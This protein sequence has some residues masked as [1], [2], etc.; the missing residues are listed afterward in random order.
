MIDKSADTIRITP[1]DGSW[2]ATHGSQ[3]F[4]GPEE[5]RVGEQVVL[6]HVDFYID[7]VA[8]DAAVVDRV[9]AFR[10]GGSAIVI[11]EGFFPYG[12]QPRFTQTC[13]YAANH[14]RVT[15]DLQWPRGGVVGRHLG[16]GGARLP[17]AW[18]RYRCV[19]PALHLAHET[20]SRQHALAEP[21][22]PGTMAGH[23]HRP[24]L[25]LVFEGQDGT[26]CE[27]GTGNDIWRWE[28]GLGYG[29]ESGSFKIMHEP[30]GLRLIREP[31]MCCEPF[32]PKPRTY[33]FTWYAAW[34]GKR[35][36]AADPVPG[37]TV[38]MPLDIDVHHGIRNVDPSRPLLLDFAQIPWPKR[39]QRAG[40]P[41][42]FARD[43]RRGEPCWQSAGVQKLARRVIR[44]LAARR[45]PGRLVIRGVAPG[46]CWD[47]RHLD[48]KRPDGIAHWDLVSILDYAVWARAQL[49]PA[50]EIE[51]EPGKF[52]DLPSVTGL[53]SNNGFESN[54][55]LDRS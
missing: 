53:F 24:P 16:V 1:A 22:A 15:F 28:N 44:Q 47:P 7:D 29:I 11:S 23:W 39:W 40:S 26:T 30:G 20:K 19:P 41:A 32:E 25:A 36:A 45:S 54:L 35:P 12:V 31:L 43:Q 49:G 38:G 13:R 37:S 10:K 5:I 48:R 2:T 4:G 9:R 27:I 51:I 50:W 3:R 42:A 8:G 52:G 6:E 21:A 33:R 55:A 46:V 14:V 17:G 34:R 18:A